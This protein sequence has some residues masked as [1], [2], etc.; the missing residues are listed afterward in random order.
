[1]ELWD[2]KVVRATDR[3][4]DGGLRGRR[5]GSQAL[6]H[7]CQGFG[8]EKQDREEGQ[9]SEAGEMNPQAIDAS[10][11]EMFPADWVKETAGGKC[12]AILPK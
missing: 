5:K 10:L 6:C 3:D 8:P 7:L 4:T 9:S 12:A 2:N 1:M 11:Y